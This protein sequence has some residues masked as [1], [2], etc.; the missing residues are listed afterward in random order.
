[1]DAMSGGKPPDVKIITPSDLQQPSPGKETGNLAWAGSRVLGGA[2]TRTF[3]QIIEDEKKNRNIIEIQITRP[4]PSGDSQDSAPRPLTYDDLG[5]LIFDIIKIDPKDCITFDYNTGRFDTKQIQLKPAIK[6]DQFLTTTPLL[7]KGYE[8]SV[9]KQLNNITRVTFKN[10]PINVPNEEILH[11]CKSYGTPYDNKVY[12]E[13]LT[14]S[15][16]KGMQG[17]TRFVDM[18]LKKNVSMMNYYWMEGP[19]SGDQGRRVL[20]LHNGQLSQCSH[21]LRQAGRGGCPAGGN[22]KACKQMNEPRAKMHLYMQG[23]RTHAGYV[24]LKTMYMEHQAKNYPSLPGFDSD[25]TS[26]ME[27]VEGDGEGIVPV[28][29]I[30]EK[31]NQIAELEKRVGELEPKETEISQLKEALAKSKLDLNTSLKKLDF[32]QKATEKRILESIGDSGGFIA[33][34]VL[35]G[36]YSA[37]LDE[38]DFEFSNDGQ[39]KSDGGG[40][41]RKGAFLKSMED[42]LDPKNSEHVERFKIIKNQILEKVKHTQISRSRSRSWSRGSGSLKRE[43]SGESLSSVPG[44]SPVRPRTSGIPQK[45]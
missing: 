16:N 37:T 6:V 33:D 31:D 29:P 9:T 24:S 35:I 1:M 13:T 32:T 25:I 4:A 18:E 7:F 8:V 43:L 19:L 26:N 11:V 21:C 23:L 15:R 30:E 45:K 39:A 14:N 41:S 17:S 40:R 20:V 27:E 44:N 34:P 28:N 22:G 5:E 10:V 42:K 36:V 12:Y 2:N 38:R 3:Q